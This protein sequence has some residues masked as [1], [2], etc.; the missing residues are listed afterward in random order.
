MK[1]LFEHTN[2]LPREV[3]EVVSSWDNDNQTYEECQ[4]F[5][6]ELEKYGYTFE[7]GLDAVPYGLRKLNPVEE[8]NG[9]RIF[10]SVPFFLDWINNFLSI[11][12][13]A[14]YYG[15]TESHAEMIINAGRNQHL[16]NCRIVD[17]EIK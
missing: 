6:K 3:R 8:E 15:I 2:E 4:K 12:G 9:K 10:H 13:I 11:G 17:N 7:Y 1:D 5:L 16:Q 14:S